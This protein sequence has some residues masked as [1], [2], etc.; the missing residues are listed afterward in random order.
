MSAR[1][2]FVFEYLAGGATWDRQAAVPFASELLDEGW[3]MLAAVVDDLHACSQLTIHTILDCRLA[4]RNFDPTFERVDQFT[5]SSPDE[6]DTAFRDQVAET[7]ATIVIAPEIGNELSRW[8]RRVVEL[9]GW[10]VGSSLGLIDLASDKLATTEWLGRGGIPVPHVVAWQRDE[11]WPA[12]P[13][14]PFFAKPRW[15][16][17]CYG[18]RRIESDAELAAW[19][20]ENGQITAWVFESA[21][22]GLAASV[23]VVAAA[24]NVHLLTPQ[25]QEFADTYHHYVG[26]EDLT[27][28]SLVRRSN[29][30]ARQAVKVLPP[31][32]GFIGID[33]I[34]GGDDGGKDDY[35]IEVNPRLTTSFVRLRRRHPRLTQLAFHE[36]FD[37]DTT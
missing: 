9:G 7:D 10:L 35:I 29:D 23:A 34:L 20:R 4:D 14:F 18:V 11:P 31:F 32:N 13:S 1:R 37:C 2:V 27:N 19:L 22:D 5:V 16:A 8:S 24:G 26:G 12:M 21:C 28:E 15:G 17:G 3:D 36:L 33:I 6:L 25:S 30:L